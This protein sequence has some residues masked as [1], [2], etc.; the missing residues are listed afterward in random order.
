MTKPGYLV[1]GIDVDE[2]HIFRQ[3]GQGT[4]PLLAKFGG[5]VLSATNRIEI[6]DGN[7]SRGRAAVLKFPSLERARAFWQAPEYT[8]LKALRESCS[9]S[10]VVLVEGTTDED[11]GAAPADEGTPH[12]M[13]GGND[14]KDLSWIPEYQAKV[15]PISARYGLKA[16]I[17]SDQFDVLD[18][19]W[20]RQ[21]MILLKFPSEDA[22]RRFWSDPDYLPLKTL[23]E[24][25]TEGDHITFPGGYDPI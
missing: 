6:L 9:R 3:Y 16:L 14:T 2:P 12:Y 25:N 11:P 21:S 20:D 15:P 7:L 8:P 5:A 19:R 13:L 22:Y 4:G 23:R 24:D 17:A 10:D 18:G 1:F